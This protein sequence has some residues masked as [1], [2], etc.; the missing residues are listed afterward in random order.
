VGRLTTDKLDAVCQEAYGS[1]AKTLEADGNTRKQL[2]SRIDRGLEQLAAALESHGVTVLR[3]DPATVSKVQACSV[4]FCRDIAAVIGSEIIQSQ[5]H[6]EHR[7]DEFEPS[8]VAISQYFAPVPAVS[9]TTVAADDLS[10]MTIPMLKQL[11]N[12]KGL[13]IPGIG[14]LRKAELVAAIGKALGRSGARRTCCSYRS[15]CLCRWRG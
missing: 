12:A 11:V 2:L 4:I 8:R 15:G 7:K 6:L 9:Y 3:P 5:L 14:K 1:I 10:E 13:D